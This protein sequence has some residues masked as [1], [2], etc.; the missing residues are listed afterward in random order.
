MHERIRAQHTDTYVR[1]DFSE[2][3]RSVLG[4]KSWGVGSGFAV[5]KGVAFALLTP[6]ACP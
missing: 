2:V 5:V 4:H 6:P 1:H 3:F